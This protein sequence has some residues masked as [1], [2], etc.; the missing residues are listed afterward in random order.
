MLRNPVFLQ[1]LEG[2]PTT[3]DIAIFFSGAY[4]EDEVVGMNRCIPFNGFKNLI[5]QELYSFYG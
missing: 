4:L 2:S 5:S 1:R 3:K